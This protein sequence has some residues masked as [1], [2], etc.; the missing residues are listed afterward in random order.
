VLFAGLLLVV[1]TWQGVQEMAA[2]RLT[3]GQLVSF[4]GYAVPLPWPIQTFFECVQRWAIGLVSARKA[5][6]LLSLCSPWLEP[7]HPAG[8]V[9]GDLVDPVSGLTVRQGRLAVEVAGRLLRHRRVGS[10]VPGGT[11]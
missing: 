11:S 3:S 4:F 10:V 1:L 6:T 5:I 2:G 7:E 9:T 8:I